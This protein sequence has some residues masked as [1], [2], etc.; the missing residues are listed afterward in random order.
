MNDRLI[1]LEQEFRAALENARGAEALS[2]LRVE[3]FGKKGKLTA[4]LRSVGELPPGERPAFGNRVNE[5]RQRLEARLVD[6]ANR[7]AEES[8]DRE[9]RSE[10]IDVHWPGRRPKLGTLHPLT[11]VERKIVRTFESLGFSVRTG[12]DVE[13]DWYNFEALNFPPEHP[14]RDMQDTFFLE[15]N[16]VL[17]T[18]TSPVQIRTMERQAPPVQIVIP[19]RVY[20]HDSD[21]THSPVFHQVEGLCVGSGVTFAHLKGTLETFVHMMFGPDI[22]S[23][24][25]P[26]F[27]PF[28]EPSAE[29]DMQC[30]SCKGKGCRICKN[31]GWI[32][33][34]GCGM[35]DP[36]VLDFVGRAW[37]ARGETNPY[38][39]EKVSGFAWGMGIE[40]VAMV[41]HGI[42]DIRLFYENDV[43]FLGQFEE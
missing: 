16:L 27:F 34:L 28:T 15:N 22:G 5:A 2:G 21:V 19:G 7:A 14:A 9:V 40:R 17:R 24:F 1:A 13:T 41:L 32:E 30:G 8:E 6:K 39:A 23:R 18:H 38:D 43:R 42:D 26:S 12:P 35:V 36:N 4:L 3:Y 25:R 20:R 33:I 31:T 29:L 11:L 37:T 10:R